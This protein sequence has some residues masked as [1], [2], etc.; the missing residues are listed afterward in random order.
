[1]V[2]WL[3]TLFL[4]QVASEGW[5]TWGHAVCVWGSCT[6]LGAFQLVTDVTRV[7]F[8]GALPC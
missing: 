5:Q 1:M 7:L 3:S 8:L 6:S 4:T 2:W